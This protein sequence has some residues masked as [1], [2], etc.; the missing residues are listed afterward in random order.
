VTFRP[1][2]SLRFYLAT[3]GRLLTNPRA[4]FSEQPP[5]AGWSRP[6]GML[7]V[8][9]LLFSGASLIAQPAPHPVR[10]GLIYFANAVGMNFI[11]AAAGWLII[12]LMRGRG[13]AFRRVFSIYAL[14]AG[15]TLLAS[16][17]P[18]LTIITELWKWWLIGTGMTRG[19]DL[20]RSQALIVVGISI[21]L[22]I[23]FFWS[24]QALMPV[25]S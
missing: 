9:S 11:A 15:I 18:S 6:L 17:I 12:A 7:A 14:A 10:L 3:L 19:L 5:E 20:P 1:A 21:A 2:F 22:I 8:S 4:V 25:G 24:L 23:V 13:V 16:W